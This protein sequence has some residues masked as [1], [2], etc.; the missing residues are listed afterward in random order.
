M[1][2]DLQ[3]HLGPSL[4]EGASITTT[5]PSRWSDYGA[6]EPIAVVRVKSEEDVAT[7]V[8]TQ[9]IALGY[10]LFKLI[11]VLG[12]ILQLPEST[13]PYSEWRK[14][15]GALPAHPQSGHDRYLAAQQ[16]ECSE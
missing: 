6:P 7:T 1:S 12:K 11:F 10:R 13:I 2:T 9:L 15:V 5:V 8:H 4:A 16:R 3:Q 14:W